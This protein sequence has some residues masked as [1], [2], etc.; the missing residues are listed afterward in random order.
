MSRSEGEDTIRKRSGWLIPLGVLLVVVAMSLVFLFFYL[1]PTPPPLFAEQLS[2]T[3][4]TDIVAL[5]VG[6]LKLWIPANYLEFDS[7]RRGGVR[8]EVALF[9]MLPDLSGWSNWD[10]QSFADNGANSR[11]VYL[12]IRQENVS[13]PEDERLRRIYL[14]YLADTRGTPGPF[15]LTQYAFRGDSGYHDQDLFVGETDHG[16]ALLRCERL[17]PDNLSPKCLRD[18][19]L[20]RGVG[21]SYRFKRAKLSHWRELADSVEKFVAV[22]EKPPK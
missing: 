13:L 8:R 4:S 11:I 1:V 3:S 10:A 12:L 22:I 18:M 15:G 6:G 21:I 19:P 20:A 17:G 5:D 7:T 9:A 14:G 2:P 16:I